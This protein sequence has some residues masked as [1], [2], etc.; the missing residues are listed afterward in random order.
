M[1]RITERYVSSIKPDPDK[2]RFYW[3]DQL[4]GFGVR[5]SPSGRKTYLIQ[6]RNTNRRTRRYKL[7]VWG[8]LK[9]DK[10][11]RMARELLGGIEGGNDPAK[12]RHA[13]RYAPAVS[14]LAKDYL[15][16]HGPKKRASSLRNDRS[17]LNRY[18]LPHLG[19]KSVADVTRWDVL[20]LHHSMKDTPY[21]AN[22]ALAVLSKMFSLAI[23]WD[24]RSDNPV[25]GTERYAESPRERWLNQE[26]LGRLFDALAAHP[27][28]QIADAVRILILTGALIDRAIEINGTRDGLNRSPP[29]KLRTGDNRVID[30]GA[31]AQL[32]DEEHWQGQPH[33]LLAFD[34]VVQFL[35]QQVRFLM[36]WVRSTDENERCRIVMA[37]NPPVTAVGQWIIPMYAPVA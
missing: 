22:R 14:D 28:Q 17:M 1:S 2:G 37:S 15:E 24:W 32:G 18:I 30:F 27:N 8:K 29:P 13:L 10:A 21:Q 11:R 20:K 23:Q 25:R 33:S 35:E 16:H 6:Y 3:D 31:A 7:G 36:G 26:E 12:E 34:E 9:A 19:K 4:K 5:V